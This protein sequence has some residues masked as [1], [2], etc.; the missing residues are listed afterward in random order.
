MKKFSSNYKSGGYSEPKNVSQQNIANY[1][2][3]KC[4]NFR[5]IYLIIELSINEFSS[6]DVDVEKQ[7]SCSVDYVI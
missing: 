7:Q 3:G 5:R 2:F 6:V 4:F 1:R